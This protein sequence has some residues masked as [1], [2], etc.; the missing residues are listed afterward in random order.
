VSKIS[1]SG[2][3]ILSAGLAGCTVAPSVEILGSFFPA[4]LAC[5]VVALAPAALSRVLLLRAGLEAEVGP[6]VLFYP[7]LILLFTC[8]GWLAFFS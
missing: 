8:V 1:A 7:C 5:L 6:L 4:W 2:L 3:A